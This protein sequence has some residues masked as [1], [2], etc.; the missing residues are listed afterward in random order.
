MHGIYKVEEMLCDELEKIGEKDEL[1]AGSLETADKLSHAL[2]NV[3]KIIDY[4]EEMGEDDGYSGA[5][6]QGDN[7]GGNMGGTTG[8]SYRGGNYRGGSYARDGRGG[9]T[10]SNQYGIY[11]RG[12]SYARG[13]GRGR[14]SN[15]KRD[16]MGRYSSRGGRYSREGGY[17]REEGTEE[18]VM[19]L[20]EL[21]QD[22][23]NEEIRQRM[24]EL[25]SE[26]EMM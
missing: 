5:G 14:G 15:A 20:R 17:S 9:R 23:P 3:Q 10:G 6:G 25:V 8:G 4:Y 12:G 18:M 2:K 1:T 24:Q 11:A 22:A 19:E 16:S 13:D 21:M 26:I 7:M